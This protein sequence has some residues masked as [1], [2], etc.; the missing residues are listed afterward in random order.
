MKKKRFIEVIDRAQD[1]LDKGNGFSC[2]AIQV[3]VGGNVYN[4]STTRRN[5][6]KYINKDGSSDT[7]CY[8]NLE[9][10]SDEFYL[11]RL[12]GLEGYKEYM[13]ETGGYKSL[14]ED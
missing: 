3:S 9:Y 11:Q 10:G 7:A 13:L 5:Y 8:G 4:C 1:L 2:H 6:Q 12:F 14:K